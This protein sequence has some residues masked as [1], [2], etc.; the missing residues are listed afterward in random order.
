MSKYIIELLSGYSI[1]Q[2]HTFTAQDT[3]HF[4]H[5]KIRFYCVN[6]HEDTPKVS[7]ID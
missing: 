5:L 4:L 1:K 7:I 3:K 2:F 6:I